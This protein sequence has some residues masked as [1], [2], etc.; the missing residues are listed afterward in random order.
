MT[1]EEWQQKEGIYAYE[2]A[3]AARWAW[4]VADRNAREEC[5][6]ICDYIEEYEDTYN[7]NAWRCAR[8][9]RLTIKE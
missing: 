3:K 5:A 2:V 9:I 8:D 1:F 6:N 7:S 4:E